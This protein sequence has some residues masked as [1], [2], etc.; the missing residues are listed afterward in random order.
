MGYKNVFQRHEMKYL[1]TASQQKEI[2]PL[3]EPYMMPDPYGRSVIRNLY[4]DTDNYRLARSSIEHPT[5]KEKLRIRSYGPPKLDSLIFVELKKKYRSVVFK[6]RIAMKEAQALQWL[7][8]EQDFPDKTQ[9]VKE[10]DYFMDYY[11]SLKPSIFLSYERTAYL[12]RFESDLRITFDD[13]ILANK[14]Q[15]SLHGPIKG[16][17]FLPQDMVLM[18]IKSAWGMPLWLTT[19]LSAFQLYKTSFSKYG[20]AYQTLI[21]GHR[22]E[23]IFDD[24]L[25]FSRDLR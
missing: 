22:K 1:L 19:V 20:I 23:T 13:T 16:I 25:V 14:N 24:I 8:R 4:Y 21:L 15:L 6:R 10:I 2:I 12:S 17:S 7:S 9:I 11:K 18:E 3:L 5:Y